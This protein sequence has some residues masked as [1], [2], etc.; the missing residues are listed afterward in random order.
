MHVRNARSRRRGVDAA[1]R[2]GRRGVVATRSSRF[3]TREGIP[4]RGSG[5]LP[6]VCLG[7]CPG[8]RRVSRGASTIS[9]RAAWAGAGS[10]T[11]VACP[12]FRGA[13]EE[14]GSEGAE[15][16]SEAG[17]EGSSARAAGTSGDRGCRGRACPGVCP[18]VFQPRARGG[19]GEAEVAAGRRR[20]DGTEDRARRM[21]TEI[22]SDAMPTAT[23]GGAGAAPT[24]DTR[25]VRTCERR[26]R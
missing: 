10:V 25:C 5:Y 1:R 3:A 24:R 11:R 14:A 6:A 19:G 12:G 20:P 23:R 9:T 26:R 17:S 2:I 15:A 4:R 7:V 21:G 18:E 22:S 13:A 8:T 16:G